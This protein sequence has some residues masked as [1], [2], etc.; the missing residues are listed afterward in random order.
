MMPDSWIGACTFQAH[1][2]EERT[3]FREDLAQECEERDGNK[4]EEPRLQNKT[5]RHVTSTG[6]TLHGDNSKSSA[7]KVQ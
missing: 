7:V 4:L 2:V 5:A 3:A 1:L 6:Q